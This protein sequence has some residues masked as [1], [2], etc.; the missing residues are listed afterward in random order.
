MSSLAPVRTKKPMHDGAAVRQPLRITFLLPYAGL[1]GG[2]RVVA[3][4]ADR[5]KAR[6]H[7]VVILSTPYIPRGLKSK[8]RN[9][10]RRFTMRVRGKHEPSHLNDVEVEHRRLSSTDH[11]DPRDIPESD[12]VVATWWQTA[13]NLG[14]IE[15]NGAA[16]AYFIQ[17]YEIHESQPIERV[18]ATWRL[19]MPKIVVAQW[20][21]DIARNEYADATALTVP[22]AVDLQQFSV[23]PRTKQPQPTV[24]F[25]YSNA[26]FKGCDIIGKAIEIAR[27]VVPDLQVVAFGMASSPDGTPHL[28]AGSRYSQTPQ[29][30]ALKH[31]YASCDAWLFGSRSEGFGLPL[32]EAMASRT[33]VIATPTGAAPELAAGGGGMLVKPEDPQDM[34]E[35]IVRIAKMPEDQWKRISDLAWQTASAYT[36]DDATDRF[37]AALYEAISRSHGNE[38]TAA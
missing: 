18:K 16:K 24:G 15:L 25:M 14:R 32:L 26:R 22:N 1:A 11:L 6:G 28:P 30:D 27:Q 8:A 38:R 12:V 23:Q 31:I 10:W 3:I 36:W 7:R 21:S 13:E 9:L 19:P 34:A 29:Q 17:H 37:E 5:L 20:L 2:I 35:A 33:P 4:Y